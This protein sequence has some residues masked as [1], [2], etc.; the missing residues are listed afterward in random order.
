MKRLVATGVMALAAGGVLMSASPAMAWDEPNPHFH[1]N[2]TVNGQGIGVQTCRDVNVGVIGAGIHN[3]L[4]VD[5]ESGN[6]AN[7]SAVSHEDHGH[8]GE[9]GHEGWDR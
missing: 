5:N 9:F 3:L 6:C 8:R 2:K 7:G 4:G 1:S